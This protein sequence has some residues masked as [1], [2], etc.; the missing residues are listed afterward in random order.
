MDSD[1]SLE[2]ENIS[3]QQAI[4]PST[5]NMEVHHHP[6]LH[7]TKKPW[8][9]YILEY[10]MIVLAVATGFFAES[11]REN[12]GNKE[13]EKQ[14]IESLVKC[15]ASDTLQLKSI[16]NS[17]LKII[18]HLDS[19]VLLRTAD[20]GNEENKR[21]FLTH[22]LIGFVEEWY[23]KTNDAALQQLKSSGMLHL[24][25]KQII[26][27]SIFKY[28]LK[29]KTTVAQE[30]DAYFVFKESF[31]DYKKAVDLSYLSDTSVMKYDFGLNYWDVDVKNIHAI[32]ITADKE[33][34]RN[35][36]GNASVLSVTDGSYVQFMKD[37]LEYGQSLIAFLKNEY[38]LENE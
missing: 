5:Q 32:S 3:P 23:F 28:D 30:A 36:F 21:K 35:L 37:Q 34:L 7:N 18:S 33:K 20:L 15:L 11:L 25:H 24:I 6:G 13:K 1:E 14:A 12:L 29:N 8:K 4:N 26:T 22:S 10:F 16:I 27:D 38:H 19:L 9:E 17:N 2:N 31:L